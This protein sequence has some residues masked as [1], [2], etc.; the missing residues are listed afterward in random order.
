MSARSQIQDFFL[1]GIQDFNYDTMFRF[2]QDPIHRKA[3]AAEECVDQII[4]A[5]T[6]GN[7]F[8][9]D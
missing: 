9:D 2:I 8:F 1:Q 5:S 3:H 7:K 4:Y 6:H